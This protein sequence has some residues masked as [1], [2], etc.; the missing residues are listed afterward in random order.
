MVPH[1][2][3]SSFLPSP[4]AVALGYSGK[5]QLLPRGQHMRPLPGYPQD[6]EPALSGIKF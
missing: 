2:E 5:N 6:K 3:S 1:F 4:E